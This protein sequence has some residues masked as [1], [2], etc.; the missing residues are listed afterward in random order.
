MLV[1]AGAIVLAIGAVAIIVVRPVLPAD[2]PVHAAW[3]IPLAGAL[4]IV[5]GLACGFWLGRPAMV[6]TGV[7]AGMAVALASSIW[8]YNGWINATRDFKALAATVERHA[9][10]G[11]VG[12]FVS[13]GEYFQIDFY[14]GRDLKTLGTLPE[15]HAFVGAPPRPVVVVNQENWERWHRQLPP[16]LRVVDT[17]VVG[18]ETM[19]LV[20]LPP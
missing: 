15:L 20:R 10:G 13:K 4:L 5:L 9:A 12:V 7:A 2:L 19:R 17:T 11:D 3:S 16:E 1:V 8:L 6:M 14:L 18:G